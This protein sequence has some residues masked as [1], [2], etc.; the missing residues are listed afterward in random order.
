MF[1]KAKKA[2]E[3]AK[4]G[5]GKDKKGSP[6]DTEPDSQHT[7]QARDPITD[8]D[9]RSNG[10]WVCKCLDYKFAKRSECNSRNCDGT[11]YMVP[12]DENLG[13]AQLR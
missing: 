2:A 9:A 3:R 5:G 4:K 1:P 8:L 7:G 13:P 6:F 11:C 10:D 12:K